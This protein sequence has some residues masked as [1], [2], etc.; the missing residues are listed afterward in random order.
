M[1]LELWVILKLF[2]NFSDYK[3][4]VHVYQWKS[5]DMKKSALEREDHNL[6][7]HTFWNV[8]EQLRP[9]VLVTLCQLIWTTLQLCYKNSSEFFI[10]SFLL[11]WTLVNYRRLIIKWHYCRR[12]LGANHSA[13]SFICAREIN[14]Y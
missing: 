3:E 10:T 5:H 12:E 9:Q 1:I 7:T 13:M 2:S 11:H 14:I 4:R 6:Q 8:I